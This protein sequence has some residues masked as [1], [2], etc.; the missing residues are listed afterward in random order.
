MVLARRGLARNGNCAMMT[1]DT[2]LL[3]HLSLCQQWFAPCA[4][5][6]GRCLPFVVRCGTI[7]RCADHHPAGQVW[8]GS[9]RQERRRRQRN[10]D[11]YE[12]GAR[13]TDW[14]IDCLTD[15]LTNW[16]TDFM[17]KVR[18][19]PIDRLIVWLIDWLTD[20][21]TVMAVSFQLLFVIDCGPWSFQLWFAD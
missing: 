16:L 15:R 8:G 20:W 11:F 13:T 9:E 10:H 12:Q 1:G 17:N 14:Y 7:C 4:S 19:R 6:S 18:A 21:L 3:A 2:L 5:S